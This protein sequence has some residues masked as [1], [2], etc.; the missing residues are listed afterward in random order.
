MRRGAEEDEDGMFSQFYQAVKQ[1]EGH[2]AASCMA[3]IVKA[4]EGGQWQSAA[5]I[6]ER[7]FGYSARQ[8]VRVGSTDD[9]LDEVEDLI[10][11]VAKVAQALNAET[12]ED[13]AED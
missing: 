6:M 3:R 2:A 1:S 4:A 12:A 9:S 7:R 13:S 10:A 11:R 8:E 5:W